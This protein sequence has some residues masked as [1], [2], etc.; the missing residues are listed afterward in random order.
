MEVADKIPVGSVAKL[1]KESKQAAKEAALPVANLEHALT[2]VGFSLDNFT[3][4]ASPPTNP[5][6]DDLLKL[7]VLITTTDQEKKQQGS[8]RVR[9]RVFGS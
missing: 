6:L 4:Q 7:P 9:C 5:G 1:R 3:P 8:A 2:A